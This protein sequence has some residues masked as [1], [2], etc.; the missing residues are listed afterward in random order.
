M[1]ENNE[2][3]EN[4]L[5]TENTENAENNLNTENTTAETETAF[6]AE[7]SAD[8]KNL[9]GEAKDYLKNADLKKEAAE[10]K[11]FFIAMAKEPIGT[12]KNVAQT[13][14]KAFP[15][16]IASL[17]IWVVF[18]FLR[19]SLNAILGSGSFILGLMAIITRTISPIV[20]VAVVAIA[21]YMMLGKKEKGIRSFVILVAVASF[22][23]ALTSVVQVLPTLL[24]FASIVSVPV[25]YLLNG[26]YWLLIFFGLKTMADETVDESFFLPFI[27]VMIIYVVA[28]IVLQPLGIMPL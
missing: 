26:I 22:P 16:A 18:N 3:A 25:N 1:T 4:K 19:H 21:A 12:I 8:A 15:V 23:R 2:N 24:P 17:A 27:K 11:G 9:A 6:T 5:N 28:R 20:L 14:D 7:A 10:A 13:P